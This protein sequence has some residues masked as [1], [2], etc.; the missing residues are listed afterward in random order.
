VAQRGGG[1]DQFVAEKIAGKNQNIKRLEVAAKLQTRIF[2]Q[3]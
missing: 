1:D 2:H 3:A